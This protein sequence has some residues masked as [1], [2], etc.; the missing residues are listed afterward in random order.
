MN[1]C[2]FIRNGEFQKTTHWLTLS[3]QSTWSSLTRLKCPARR[4]RT[5]Q[6]TWR[7]RG[8]PSSSP[9]QGVTSTWT[10]CLETERWVS[11]SSRDDKARD[12]NLALL[13]YL[14]TG[15]GGGGGQ[16]QSRSNVHAVPR[17]IN[18]SLQK[19]STQVSSHPH[20]CFPVSKDTFMS[21]AYPELPMLQVTRWTGSWTRTGGRWSLTLD[22]R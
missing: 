6:S 11:T 7:Q 3:L 15:R 4:A 9:R 12:W 1:A 10:T 13:P 16:D 14:F 20:R 19:R 18:K 17:F 5:A 22:L 8:A 2:K 21:R